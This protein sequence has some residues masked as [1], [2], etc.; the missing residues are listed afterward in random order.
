MSEINKRIALWL[1]WTDVYFG[2]NGEMYAKIVPEWTSR[3]SVNGRFRDRDTDA[4]A[5]LPALVERGY[6]MQLCSVEY[7]D[8]TKMWRCNPYLLS[9]IDMCFG[10]TIAEAITSCVIQLIEKEGK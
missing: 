3:T 7:P 9:D 10:P 8:G 2:H 4:I 5:L 6:H 1:G